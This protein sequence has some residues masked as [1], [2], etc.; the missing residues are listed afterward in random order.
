M[1]VDVRFRTPSVVLGISV[2]ETF[3]GGMVVVALYDLLFSQLVS[4]I[5]GRYFNHCIS[6]RIVFLKLRIQLVYR[7]RYTQCNLFNF[8]MLT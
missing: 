1:V 8:V 2:I 3:V 7:V 4:G 5:E 6:I